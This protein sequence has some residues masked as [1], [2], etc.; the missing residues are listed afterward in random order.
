VATPYGSPRGAARKS[1]LDGGTWSPERAAA[2]AKAFSGFRLSGLASPAELGHQPISGTAPPAGRRGALGGATRGR[3][4][5]V[6]T[7]GPIG[8]AGA[9]ICSGIRW[10]HFIPRENSLWNAKTR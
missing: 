1:S 2:S 6:G 7:I 8:V 3:R 5:H 4:V 9:A 10:I